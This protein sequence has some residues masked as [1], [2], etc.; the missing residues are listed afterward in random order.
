MEIDLLILDLL[1]PSSCPFDCADEN[2]SIPSDQSSSSREFI[3]SENDE[4]M[5]SSDDVN[6]HLIM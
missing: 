1:D 3:P 6:I 4:P 2:E 5:V